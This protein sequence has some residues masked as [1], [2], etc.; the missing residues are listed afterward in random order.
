MPWSPS[1]F[2]PSCLEKGHEILSQHVF[3]KTF[4]WLAGSLTQGRSITVCQAPD[5]LNKAN[6]KTILP[7][8]TAVATCRQGTSSWVEGLNPFSF[9]YRLWAP[10]AAL[11][12]RCALGTNS[13]CSNHY[14]I[15]TNP[16]V[17]NRP[18]SNQTRQVVWGSHTMTRKQQ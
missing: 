11:C 9:P 12:L 14:A 3:S 15:E 13:N 6:A 2:W 10:F 8:L 4:Y 5:I 18:A 16:I 17:T 1:E 7:L